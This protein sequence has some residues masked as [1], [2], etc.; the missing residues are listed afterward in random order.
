MTM[1][2]DMAAVQHAA[3]VIEPHVHQTPVLTSQSINDQFGAD[4][5]FKCENFQRTGAFKMRGAMNAIM[6]I[7]PASGIEGVITHSSGNHAAALACAARLRK[8]PC[9]VVMPEDAPAF[10]QQAVKRYGAEVILCAPGM[11]SRQAKTESIINKQPGLKLVHPYDDPDVVAGLAT[12]SLEF[13]TQSPDLEML[14]LPV[15]GGGLIAGASIVLSDRQPGV[16]L[17]GV[18]PEVV[19]E[20][21][22]SIAC[23]SKSAPASARIAAAV[24]SALLCVRL[25]VV[26]SMA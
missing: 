22:Q 18:E 26:G 19:D 17:I 8:I 21:R 20:A 5:R 3:A 1:L 16:G 10:K 11:A 15:G 6:K 14:V 25:P 7:D 2:P 23:R 4:C 9:Y 12:A 24:S 13:L